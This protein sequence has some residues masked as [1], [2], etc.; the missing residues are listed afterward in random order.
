M[1]TPV[2]VIVTFA[3]LCFSFSQCEEIFILLW[4]GDA[5]LLFAQKEA[6]AS[7]EQERLKYV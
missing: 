2:K 1:S 3:F 6:R 5:D 4:F 7:L